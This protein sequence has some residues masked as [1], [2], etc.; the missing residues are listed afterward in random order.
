MGDVLIIEKLNSVLSDKF[1]DYRGAY[2]FGSRLKCQSNI[3]RKS[4]GLSK[5]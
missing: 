2:F 5:V 4:L 3:Y 1:D